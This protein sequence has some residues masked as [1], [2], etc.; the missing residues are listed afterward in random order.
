[1]RYYTCLFAICVSLASQ[2]QNACSSSKD[3]LVNISF[4]SG[5]NPG[6]SMSALDP[7]ISTTLTYLAVSG[8]PALPVPFDGYYTITNNV[9]SNNGSWFGG[10]LDHTPGD[11]NGYMAFYNASVLPGEFYKQ[12]ISGLCG[13][14]CYMF[15]I[16]VANALDPRGMDGVKPNISFVVESEAGATITLGNTGDVAQSS[17]LKWQ[18]FGLT[19]STP[20]NISTVV[21]KLINNSPGGFAT[22]GN[23]FAIDDIILRVCL[24]GE[25]VITSTHDGSNSLANN[26]INVIP[27]PANDHIQISGISDL[28]DYKIVDQLGVEVQRGYGPNVFLVGMKSG[29][30]TLI[31]KT[32]TMRFVKN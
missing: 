25:H 4:G 6:P 18:Q 7:T 20:E 21:L 32:G 5:N 12:S 26:T 15:S 22:P 14:N 11:V 19:F 31:C 23:D 28:D 3:T 1:M 2:A 24:P 13:S 29:L 8:S 17:T 10:S 27:N 16:W 9:P 30:Y